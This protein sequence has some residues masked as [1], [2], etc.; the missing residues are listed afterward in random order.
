MSRSATV[1]SFD[2]AWRI[3]KALAGLPEFE[4][5]HYRREVAFALDWRLSQ[6]D[7]A[8]SRLRAEKSPAALL[9]TP[10]RSANG[11][12]GFHAGPR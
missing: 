2:D 10:S 12:D 1:N 9:D 5:E 3:V 8:V 7:R 11:T 6:L 4:Y